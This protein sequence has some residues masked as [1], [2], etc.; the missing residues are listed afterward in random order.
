M[1]I[2]PIQLDI[3]TIAAHPGD[4]ESYCGGT[5]IRMAERGYRTGVL[6]LTA[7]GVT[8]ERSEEECLKASAE[9][10]RRLRLAWRDNQRMP[11]GR[12]ENSL[13]ARMTLAVRIRELKPRV[14]I[15]PHAAEGDPDEVNC[16][17]LG[18]EACFLAGIAK[19]EEYSDPHR[20]QRI[21]FA[22]LL[23]D[24]RPGFAVDITEQY[25]TRVETLR[26][27]G[28]AARLERMETLARFHGSR[29]GVRYAEPFVQQETIPIADIVT[30]E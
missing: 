19:L 6:D 3:L 25:E 8:T 20:P 2:A 14:L 7:G 26:S 30:M 1:I 18:L 13:A 9:A 21:L 12:L 28:D 16:R 15:L 11:D 29:I 10:A 24:V 5:L 17:A 22:S 27:Y 4:A 23:A